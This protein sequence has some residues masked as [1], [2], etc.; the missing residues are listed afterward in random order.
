ME[1]NFENAALENFAA[2]YEVLAMK[3]DLV[4]LTG[5]LLEAYN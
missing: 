2:I 1:E 5:G 4:R 3:T